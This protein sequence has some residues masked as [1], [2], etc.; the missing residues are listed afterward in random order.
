M[1]PLIALLFSSS[2]LKSV[3]HY[4]HDGPLHDRG[5]ML[6]RFLL[7]ELPADDLATIEIKDQVE[8]EEQ[9]FGRAAM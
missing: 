5:G 7:E 1:N 9:A 8:V 4:C 6:T 3:G 2:P